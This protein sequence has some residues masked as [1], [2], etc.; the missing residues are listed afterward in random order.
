M[1][2]EGGDTP[3]GCTYSERRDRHVLISTVEEEECALRSAGDQNGVLQNAT[4]AGNGKIQSTRNTRSNDAQ[5]HALPF[6]FRLP[7][8]ETIV[9][10]GVENGFH[11]R[12]QELTNLE[13]GTFENVFPAK[14]GALLFVGA[15]LVI[16]VD[17]EETIRQRKRERTHFARAIPANGRV[18]LD[19]QRF[20]CL[21]VQHRMLQPTS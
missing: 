7:Q 20:V 13:R 6:G 17:K 19:S 16:D 18:T 10:T 8:E 9:A 21:R 15:N 5:V 14:T 2:C 1:T 12:I 3:F 11:S 4:H